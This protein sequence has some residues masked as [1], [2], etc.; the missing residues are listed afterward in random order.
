VDL[1]EYDNAVRDEGFHFIAGVDEAGRGPLAGPV[2]AAAVILPHD[3]IIKGVR[4]S[5]K[6][7]LKERETLFSSIAFNAVSFAIGIIDHEE[8]DRINILNAAKA[9]MQMAVSGLSRVPDIVISDAVTIP[10]ISIKQRPVI[11]GDSKSASV[12][13][14]SIVAK[15]IRDIIMSGY[16]AIYPQYGFDRHKGYATKQHI[17]TIKKYGLCPIHRKTFRSTTDLPLEGLWKKNG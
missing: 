6:V 12:A 7:P 11:K 15:V 3:I 13:A 1:Y 17:D 9:A 16:H 10:S 5:K 14:A 8:I 4:D 2:V